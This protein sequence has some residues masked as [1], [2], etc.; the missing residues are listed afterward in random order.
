MKNKKIFGLV[1]LAM[2][3]VLGAVGF[4]YWYQNN[5][6]VATDDARVTGTVVRV[7]PRMAGKILEIY[8]DEGDVVRAGQVVARLD[9]NALPPGGNTDLTVV[10]APVSGTVISRSASPGEVGA[11]G[12]P[13]LLVVD[14]AT[15][16]VQVN[17][18]EKVIDRKSVV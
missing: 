4:Y 10:R 9:D 13:I 15:L 7:S 14:P 11:P 1:L 6:Y 3:L 8:F 2:V 5:H 16:Y 17:V 18:E 12:Q